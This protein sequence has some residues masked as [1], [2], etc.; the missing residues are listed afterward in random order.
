MVRV[1]LDVPH[2]R[3]NLIQRA[4]ELVHTPCRKEYLL[5]SEETYRTLICLAREGHKLYAKRDD[6]SMVQ[7]IIPKLHSVYTAV[8][9]RSAKKVRS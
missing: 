2:T 9:E 1:Q 7:I 3:V 5:D 6:G 8:Q 4:Q